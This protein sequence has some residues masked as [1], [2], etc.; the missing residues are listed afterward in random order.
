[1]TSTHATDGHT[2]VET[3]AEA[4]RGPVKR[5]RALLARADSEAQ[6]FYAKV[7]RYG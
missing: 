5:M 4:M 2:R 6:D 1:V 3:V 7:Q